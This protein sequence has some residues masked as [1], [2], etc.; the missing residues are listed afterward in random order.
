VLGVLGT[1]ESALARMGAPVG[2]SGVAAAAAVL[3]GRA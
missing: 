2:G 1:I 3:G